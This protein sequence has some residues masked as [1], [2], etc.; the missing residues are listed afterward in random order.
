M[1]FCLEMRQM[2]R[3]LQAVTQRIRECLNITLCFA[4][5]NRF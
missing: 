4:F 1:N 5:Q 2:L 3:D